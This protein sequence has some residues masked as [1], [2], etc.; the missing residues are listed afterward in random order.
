MNTLSYHKR[1]CRYLITE[2]IMSMSSLSESQWLKGNDPLSFNCP[3]W[4]IIENFELWSG[5]IMELVLY[6][7]L[8]VGVFMPTWS[9][10]TSRSFPWCDI[11]FYIYIKKYNGLAQIPKAVGERQSVKN[12]CRLK[13]PWFSCGNMCSPLSITLCLKVIEALVVHR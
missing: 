7:S 4:V 8:C 3:S 11:S 9:L 12:S 6:Q 13:H 10:Q 5:E 1:T 2:C